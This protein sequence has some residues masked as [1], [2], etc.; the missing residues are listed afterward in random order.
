MLLWW[1]EGG[2]H[3]GK[4]EG[5]LGA[6]CKPWPTAHPGNQV[7]GPT[8]SRNRTLATWNDPGSIFLHVLQIN[9]HHG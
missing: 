8:T 4:P 2:G 9:T 6:E 1:E 3:V 7:I 5:P